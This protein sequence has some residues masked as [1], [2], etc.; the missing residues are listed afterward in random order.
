MR[1]SAHDPGALLVEALAPLVEQVVADELDR[2][3]A[4]LELARWASL[5][6]AA[7]HL[8][9][10][11][12]VLRKRAAGGR[13]PGAVKDGSR[14]L[15]DLRALDSAL[16]GGTLRPSNADNKGPR[17]DNGRPRGTEGVS[18]DA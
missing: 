5:D 18:F 15:V 17:R 12:D 3:L 4:S 11:A 16:A 13:L 9:T 6:E 1:R 7:V 14:W 10:S 2:R 8:R